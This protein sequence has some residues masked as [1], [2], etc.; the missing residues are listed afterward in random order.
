MSDL[1][2]RLRGWRVTSQRRAVAEVPSCTPGPPH[3]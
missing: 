2:E 3:T 1:L